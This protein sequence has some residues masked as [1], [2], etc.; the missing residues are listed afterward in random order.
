[1]KNM[2]LVAGIV[3]L[4]IGLISV[5]L[6]IYYAVIEEGLM[7]AAFIVVGAVCVGMSVYSFMQYIKSK[8]TD[9]EEDTEE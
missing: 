8:K 9:M 4:I 2:L 7:A 3:R 5:G 1:M 6:G